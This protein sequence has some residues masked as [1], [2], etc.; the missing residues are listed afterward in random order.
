LKGT[1]FFY[2]NPLQADGEYQFNRGACTRQSWFDC[3]CCPTNLIR[4]VPSIPGLIYATQKDS[5]YIN[6]YISN[7]ASVKLGD[8]EIQIIQQTKYPKEGK[9]TIAVNPEKPS[10]FTLK[11][12]I[13]GW[14]RNQVLPGDLYSYLDKIP[15]NV[16]VQLRNDDLKPKIKN[17]YIAITRKWKKGDMLDISLPMSVRKVVAN[18]KV[19]DD[20]DKVAIEY[21]PFVYCAEEIDNDENLLEIAVPDSTEFNTFTIEGMPDNALAIRGN[22]SY[23]S[24]NYPLTLIPYYTWSNRG[25]GKMQVWFPLAVQ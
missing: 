13:P 6:L 15:G 19:I 3:S 10:R 16:I 8:N 17:G 12:R 11:L 25:V 4:F 24:K 20:K 14:A 5:I 21:G 1:E 2:P 9:I 7:T 23:N 18:E 22:V